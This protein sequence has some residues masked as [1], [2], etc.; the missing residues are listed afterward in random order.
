M[1]GGEGHRRV[2]SLA[3]A[4]LTLLTAVLDVGVSMAGIMALSQA[5]G[6]SE[7]TRMPPYR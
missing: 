7:N 2:G 1:S 6:L 4:G 3:V 5:L